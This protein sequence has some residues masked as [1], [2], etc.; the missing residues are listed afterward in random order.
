MDGFLS[1]SR[2]VI[3]LVA[4]GVFAVVVALASVQSGGGV[5]LYLCALFALC[6]LPVC[7]LDRVNGR[8]LLL[9]ILMAFYFIFFGML[10][11]ISVLLGAQVTRTVDGLSQAELGILC[12]AVCVLVSY[13]VTARLPRVLRPDEPAHDWPIRSILLVGLALWL[14]G[15]VS[16]VYLQVFVIP[17]K[18]IA[19]TQRGLASMGPVQIFL[20]MLGHLVAPLG[21]LILAYGYAKIR[22]TFW[23]LLILALMAVQVAVAFVTDI[24]G[25]ALLPV[26]VVIVALTLVNNKVPKAWIVGSIIGVALIFPLLSAYRAAISGERGLNRTEAV[27]NIGKVVDIVL[28]YQEKLSQRAPQAGGPMIFQRASLKANIEADFA[29]SG[30]DVPF[31][32]GR[33]LVAIPLAFI[34]RLIWPDKPDVATGQLFNREIIQGEIADVYISPSHLG[35]LYWNFGWPGL[36]LGMTFIG[37]LLGFVAAKCCLAERT[38]VTRLL[39]LLATVQYLCMGFEGAISVSYIS[40]MRS[41]AAIGLL[42]MLLAKPLGERQGAQSSQGPQAAG[43][44]PLLQGAQLPGSQPLPQGKRSPSEAGLTPALAR[45]PRFP[46]LLR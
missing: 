29:R 20:V 5:V 42:H 13:I 9:A 38:S 1:R 40:W 16:I 28:A 39:I 22:T 24:R 8:Y 7:F 34:P 45:V 4:N 37:A 23:L 31:Q 41:I 14:I 15:S 21:L 27:E 17:E 12:G 10:D 11:L 33:T 19:S 35:E 32:D 2:R 44:Q 18:T 6:S 3:Y 30:V 36:L 26:A 43:R 25:L 46:N